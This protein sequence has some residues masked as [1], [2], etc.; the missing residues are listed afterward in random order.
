VRIEAADTSEPVVLSAA[1]RIA[2]G[3]AFA[4]VLVFHPLEDYFPTSPMFPFDSDDLPAFQRASAPAVREL[5]GSQPGRLA[6]YRALSSTGKIAHAAI[7]YRVFSRLN[8]GRVEVVVEYW[9]YYVFNAFTVHGAWLP[10]RVPDNHPNDLERIYIVLAPVQ[11]SSMGMGTRTAADEDWARRALRIARVIT[12]AHDGSVPPNQYDVARG[13]VVAPPITVLVERGSHAMAPDINR[14]GRFTSSADS[15]ATTKLL[16][17]IRDHGST[18]GRYRSSFMDGRGESAVRLCHSSTASTEALACQ[19]YVLYPINDLQEW[20]SA[21]HFSQ[22]D[23]HNIV[24]Q[25]PL[26]VRA[27]GDV[28]VE[29]LMIPSDPPD[30]HV[31]DAMLHRRA[32]TEAGFVVG[33]TSTGAHVPTLVAGRRYFWDVQSRYLPDV[34]AE[35]VVLFPAGGR[36]MAE[37]TMF[38]SYSV[39]AITNVVVGVGW[40]SSAHA[41][42]D[43]LIGLDLRIGRLRVRPTWRIREGVLDSHITTTF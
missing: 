41:S 12:N 8:R 2:I 21:V 18:W 42:A 35:A 22:N 36:R 33:F 4:P 6:Q 30:G 7:Q 13:E 43:T 32:R 27:F 39:D 15:T 1:E 26:L 3:R 10:Y 31:L 5:L 28:R 9:C 38:G 23:L 20:F 11:G 16:W 34:V 25:T 17:G 40:L 24:G 37:A 19:R 14:D 29:R